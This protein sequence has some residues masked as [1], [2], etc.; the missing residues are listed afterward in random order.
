MSAVGRPLRVAV[1]GG[2]L[3]GLCTAAALAADGAEVVV[4]ERARRLEEV[5]AGIQ[6]SPNA[7]RHL[8][9]LGLGR[10]LRA[11]R[12]GLPHGREVRRW[13]DGTVVQRT[14][15]GAACAGA[16]GAPYLTLLRPDLQAALLALAGPR[17]VRTGSRVARVE[18]SADGVG[19][20][21]E[22]GS[23][24]EADVVVGADG[25]GSA[26]RA[27]LYADAPRPSGQLA[28]RG[29]VP[30]GALGPGPWAER[31]VVWLA[32]DRHLVHYP[33]DGGRRVA[34]VATV[35]EGDGLDGY[36]AW[37]PRVRAL[38]AAGRREA[39]AVAARPLQDRRPRRRWSTARCTLAGDAAH[40]ML[41][42]LAQGANQAVED[43]AALAACLRDAGPGGTATA[44]A[45]YERRRAGRAARVVRA[46]R[47]AA[48]LPD[49]PPP[50]AAR[51][52]DGT[53]ALAG[54]AWL[55]GHDA[56][57]AR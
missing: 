7:T 42:F 37:D 57:A 9:A 26:V 4:H 56:A 20:V 2:G 53:A 1:A 43:A 50:P 39:A 52:D 16:Y 12:V 35:P 55:Y 41:P 36:A 54:M 21:L 3:A 49:P 38:L 11:D 34:W 18:E 47:A 29:V 15:L 51:D 32:H 46:S 24:H 8:R 23:L 10:H 31:A 28:H 45:A 22:D 5:G 44:L 6:L 17:L 25:I 14:A 19:L 13:D 30:V 27:G 40:A 33:V 48:R